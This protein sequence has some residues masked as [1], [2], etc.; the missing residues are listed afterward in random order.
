MNRYL[1]RVTLGILAV[2]ASLA[3]AACSGDTPQPPHPT[4]TVATPPA[5]TMTTSTAAPKPTITR[6]APPPGTVT[7]TATATPLSTPADVTDAYARM[8]LGDQA[9]WLQGTPTRAEV[10]ARLTPYLTGKAY[11]V[12]AT[13]SAENVWHSEA[14]TVPSLG[15][16]TGLTA[17]TTTP[18]S[19]TQSGRTAYCTATA[20]IAVQRAGERE[21]RI[22]RTINVRLVPASARGGADWLINDINNHDDVS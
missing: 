3:L 10:L 1:A 13:G 6:V 20:A 7:R 17:T 18:A 16:P 15:R 12:L 14:F 4:V 9:L 19:C 11:H 21:L 8:S 5:T 2:A 22:A